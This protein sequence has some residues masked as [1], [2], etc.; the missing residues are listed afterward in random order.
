M[1][2]CT[3][4]PER[5]SR[6]CDFDLASRYRSWL[7]P[8]QASKLCNSDV[9]RAWVWYAALTATRMASRGAQ[10]STEP[11]L[12]PKQVTASDVFRFGF[13]GWCSTQAV[14]TSERAGERARVISIRRARVM[15]SLVSVGAQRRVAAHRWWDV[16]VCVYSVRAMVR[17]SVVIDGATSISQVATVA[18]FC[19]K[20]VHHRPPSNACIPC[21]ATWFSMC[22]H[23]VET[24]RHAAGS[25]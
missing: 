7:L 11:K 4:A 14:H 13:G 17:A 24:W 12:A 3:A 25:C 10:S 18:A 16:A 5:S 19:L 6:W 8:S 15:A 9:L 21:F 20:P 22:F 1:S 2:G 23:T